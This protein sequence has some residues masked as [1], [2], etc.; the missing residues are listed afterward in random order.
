ML[1]LVFDG[2]VVQIEAEEFDVHEALVWVDIRG[3][4]PAPV[5]GS[6]YDGTVFTPPAVPPPP[7][8]PDR[9][10]ANLTAEEIATELV[11]KG[12]VSRAEFDTVK[13]SR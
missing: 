2:K 7:K 4:V 1:A 6:T 11:R 8:A 5:V 12:L 10:A 3:I 13:T 9:V